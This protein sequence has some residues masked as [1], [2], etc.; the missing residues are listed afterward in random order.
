MKL[1]HFGRGRRK[2]AK[3]IDFVLVSLFL[4]SR[5]QSNHRTDNYSFGGTRDVQLVMWCG[6][7]DWIVYCSYYHTVSCKIVNN[8]CYDA[9]EHFIGMNELA[10]HGFSYW[11]WSANDRDL[12][13]MTVTAMGHS[14]Y[15]K[16]V[17]FVYRLCVCCSVECEI[18]PFWVN[19]D[20]DDDD[21]LHNRNRI[22]NWYRP[23]SEFPFDVDVVQ[24]KMP[25][26]LNLMVICPFSAT[27]LYS[28]ETV[29]VVTP[30]ALYLFGLFYIMLSWMGPCQL[31]VFLCARGWKEAN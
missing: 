30:P 3:E 11:L 26:P 13:A 29:S 1:F 31:S 15:W 25:K 19:D 27:A 18:F 7:N 16:F 22:S 21:S 10:E 20:D 2:I 4:L 24:H 6:H 28:L 23:N 17:Q 8:N 12:M 9:K 14:I 5:W